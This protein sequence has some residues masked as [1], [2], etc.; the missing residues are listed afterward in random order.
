MDTDISKAGRISPA[1]GL[2]NERRAFGREEREQQERS[3]HSASCLERQL[4]LSSES[5][6]SPGRIFSV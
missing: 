3:L 6:A 5:N 1:L 4:A 2:K